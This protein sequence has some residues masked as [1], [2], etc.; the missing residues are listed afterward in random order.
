MQPLFI[1]Y[2]LYLEGFLFSW[3]C[4]LKQKYYALISNS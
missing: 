1:F 2:F 3:I 4:F